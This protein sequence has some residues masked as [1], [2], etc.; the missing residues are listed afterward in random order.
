MRTLLRRSWDILS[1]HLSKASRPLLI[2][3]FFLTTPHLQAIHD[4]NQNGV[5][6]LWEQKFNNGYLFS[7]F[8]P[9][10]D[11]DGDGWTNSQEASAGTDPASGVGVTGLVRPEITQD[12]W[13]ISVTWPTVAGKKYTLFSSADLTPGGWTQ[14]AEPHTGNGSAIIESFPLTWPDGTIPERN[15]WRVTVTDQDNDSDTLTD[16]EETE[17]GSSP[18]SSDGD[19]DELTDLAELFTHYTNPMSADGD[20]DGIS[21]SDEILIDFTSPYFAFDNDS[22]GIPDDYERHL[23]RQLLAYRPSPA[24]W[25]AFYA[26]L[27]AGNLDPTHSYTGDGLTALELAMALKNNP[28]AGPTR[29][30]LLVEQQYR[31]NH[32]DSYFY[33]TLPS[34]WGSSAYYKHSI[35]NSDIHPETRFVPSADLGSEYLHSRINAVTWGKFLEIRAEPSF[36]YDLEAVS[37]FEINPWTDPI[38]YR[39][40]VISGIN[41]QGSIVEK[42]LRILANDAGHKPDSRTYLAVMGSKTEFRDYDGN[43]DKEIKVIESKTVEIP[44]GRMISDWIEFRAPPANGAQIKKSWLRIVPMEPAPRVLPVNSDFDEGRIDPLTGYAIP[45]CDDIPGVDLETGAGNTSLELGAKR[46]HLDGKFTKD[47]WVVKDLHQGWFGMLPAWKDRLNFEGANITIRKV[48]K[49]DQDTGY[50]ESGHVRFY[51]KWPGAYFGIS[52][53]DFNTLEPVNLVSG[54]IN[55]RPGEGIYSE[56]SPIPLYAKFYMEGVRPGKI[57][58]EWRLQRG[59]IDVK[60]EQTFNVETRKTPAE[61][62]ADLAYK[63]RLDTNNDPS[64]QIDVV[65]D[66]RGAP[67]DS[68]STVDRMSEY[69]DYY[70]ENYLLDDDF[71]WCGMARLAGSQVLTGVSD[72]SYAVSGP[73]NALYVVIGEL[74]DSL[75]NGGFDIFDSIAWQ[76]HAYRSSGLEALKWT[77]D[78]AADDDLRA[79]ISAWQNYDKGK[80]DSDSA[81]VARAAKAIT[82][83]EQNTVIVRTWE[84]LSQIRLENGNVADVFTILS[85]NVMKPNGARFAVAVPGGDLGNTANRWKWIDDGT[86]G[87]PSGIIAA[88]KAAGKAGQRPLVANTIREDGKRFS[89]AYQ[90]S[91]LP[92]VFVRDHLDIP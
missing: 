17:L 47:E 44:E 84:D 10:A 12:L 63:I 25:G 20:A 40:S 49:I 31:W 6:D 54:G 9:A 1:Q 2:L 19:N 62:K 21:D 65:V 37:A 28:A 68:W 43:I 53:Y 30:G 59:D 18:Y 8:D 7:T 26:G 60:F 58:L 3:L 67:K 66:P 33:F 87:S 22:D 35:P 75:R 92:L 14:V 52:P 45:D 48:G 77:K 29:S 50:Q 42:R 51:A 4:T 55:G 72:A 88:W 5:S 15:F 64:G 89:L 36:L 23:A 76:H 56:D 90:V 61:W 13:D 32:L 85:E 34:W 57:T 11:P 81:L 78:N 16:T 70:R 83:Y 41:S 91:G 27:L 38:T 73:S 46:D 86:S 79:L 39:P 69:Y 82:Q 24:A 80:K 71:Q 74:I